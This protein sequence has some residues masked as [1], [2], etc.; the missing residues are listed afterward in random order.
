MV[1]T[2]ALL[3]AMLLLA[4]AAALAQSDDGIPAVA[5]PRSPIVNLSV[6]ESVEAPPNI[7]TINTGVETRALTAK[8]AMSQ[9]A[10]KIDA[11]IAALLKAGIERKD[12]QTSGI[13]L[14]PQYDYSQRPNATNEG[15]RF[16]GYQANNML[17]VVIRKIDKAGE[18]VDTMVNA[19]ATNINGPQFS[20]EDT[21]KLQ[22]QARTKAVKTAQTRADFYAQAAGY[23][24]ARLLLISETGEIGRPIIMADRLMAAAPAAKTQIEPGQL[25][26][27]ITLN[28][29]YML[30]R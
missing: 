30:E 1:R 7:A 3:P 12:I 28:F 18:I 9:N 10:A 26:S 20:I 13:N 29:R 6:T 21:S 24:T 22:E 16:I 23:K 27:S 15:P 19:G 2:L 11:L 17:T 8:D 4:P 25:S 14:N 5:V